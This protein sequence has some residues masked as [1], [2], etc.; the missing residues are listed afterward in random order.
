MHNVLGPLKMG[1]GV[2]NL[3]DYCNI[4]YWELG[5]GYQGYGPWTDVSKQLPD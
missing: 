2:E 3:F 4:N 1:K 5:K